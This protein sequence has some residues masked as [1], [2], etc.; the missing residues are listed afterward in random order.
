MSAVTLPVGGLYQ[1]YRAGFM[2]CRRSWA[3]AEAR[4]DKRNGLDPTSAVK[5]ARYYS[6]CLV[7]SLRH[8][9]DLNGG[10][11]YLTRHLNGE[12]KHE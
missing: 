5:N 12:L 11:R 10:E 9:R 1:A 4:A 6:R 8:A 7:E 2:K 3:M